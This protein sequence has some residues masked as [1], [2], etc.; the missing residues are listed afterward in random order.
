M[1]C[2][3]ARAGIKL[4]VI[5]VKKICAEL[6][7]LTQPLVTTSDIAIGEAL[8]PPLVGVLLLHVIFC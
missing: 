3:I 6:K 5:I 8:V 4:A 1:G 2:A 7:I